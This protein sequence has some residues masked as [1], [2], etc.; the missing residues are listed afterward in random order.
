VYGY[1]LDAAARVAVDTVT[2][3]LEQHRHPERVLLVAFD[4]D[5][6][7]TL[8]AALEAAG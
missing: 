8:R 4:A 6:A 5:T 7:D 3:Y 2:A 1:P